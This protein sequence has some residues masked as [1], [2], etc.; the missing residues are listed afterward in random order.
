M[1][2]ISVLLGMAD[3]SIFCRRNPSAQSGGSKLS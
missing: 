2:E 1:E 3:P